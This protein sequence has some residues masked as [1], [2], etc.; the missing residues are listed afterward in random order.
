[1]RCVFIKGLPSTS[2]ETPFPPFYIHKRRNHGLNIYISK[3]SA[4]VTTSVE[5]PR[6]LAV[7][8]MGDPKHPDAKQA[9]PKLMYRV[10]TILRVRYHKLSAIKGILDGEGFV[11]VD[12]LQC[13]IYHPQ[14]QKQKS[15]RL[16]SAQPPSLVSSR[17]T[18]DSNRTST[19]AQVYDLSERVWSLSFQENEDRSTTEDSGWV[20]YF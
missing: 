14:S 3:Q 6:S 15:P 18:L 17:S 11:D 16:F 2:Y 5:L 13:S 20:K 7:W 10:G 4:E 8:L 9:D 19:P 12:K 1:M